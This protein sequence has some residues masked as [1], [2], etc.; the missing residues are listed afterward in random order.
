M[1]VSGGFRRIFDKSGTVPFF[2]I[3]KGVDGAGRAAVVVKVRKILNGCPF[4]FFT[5]GKV[6]FREFQISQRFAALDL[7]IGK[8]QPAGVLIV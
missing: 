5:S 1:K 7:E 6:V 2:V 4:H 3:Q 8:S